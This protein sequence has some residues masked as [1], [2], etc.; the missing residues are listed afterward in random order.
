MARPKKVSNNVEDAAKLAD[1]LI[2][3]E[4]AARNGNS[5]DSALD[6][7]QVDESETN[8]D[9]AESNDTYDLSN[10]EDESNVVTED[11]DLA[12]KYSVLQ[13]KYE[14]ETGRLSRELS[15]LNIELQALK[16]QLATKSSVSDP[17]L[18]EASSDDAGVEALREQYPELYKGF[19]LLA[20]QEAKAEVTRSFKGTSEKVDAIVRESDET[21]K[22][23]Y[24]T[25]LSELVP[26][27]EQINNHP[28]FAKW[29]IE[30][31]EF[32]GTN[33]RNLL[34]SAF[35]RLDAVTSA[36]FFNAFIKE[37]GIKVRG[38][39]SNNDDIAPDTSGGNVRP[40][41]RIRAGEVTRAEMQQFYQDKAHGR[42]SG[43]EAEINKREARFFQ[44]VREGKVIG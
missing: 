44:A 40:Q 26:A 41:S 42:L 30:P 29:L 1:E 3:L 11:K 15:Q 8:L 19:L 18:D 17:A 32:S 37:K 7:N 31:D 16:V 34:G 6:E 13:G 24:Y 5:N 35:N 38:Q 25:K 43:T 27:W 9:N 22:A 20:R 21:K 23:N 10:L 36:K 4:A 33:R 39:S 12:H 14:A 2:A 28:S